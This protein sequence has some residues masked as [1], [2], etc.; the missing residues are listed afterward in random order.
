MHE[1][2]KPRVWCHT[3]EYAFSFDDG[4]TTS[5]SSASPFETI[6]LKKRNSILDS[7]KMLTV[8]KYPRFLFKWRKVSLSKSR[9]EFGPQQVSSVW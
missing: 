7:S 2:R 4:I 8:A 5:T 9:R 3:E 1:V 6:Q